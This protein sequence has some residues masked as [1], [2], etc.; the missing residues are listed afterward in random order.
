[1]Q[2]VFEIVGDPH[3]GRRSGEPV[4]RHSRPAGRCEGVFWR[5]FDRK[6][7]S[8]VLQ[9]AER[10]DALTRRNRK[11]GGRNG[12]LGHIGRDVLRELLRLI[13]YRTGRLDPAIGTLAERLGYSVPAV[14][15]ALKRLRAA[16][17]VDWL[18][19]Y[20]PTGETGRGP[21]VQQTSNAYRVSLP[22]QAARL[23]PAPAPLP[24]DF[25][26]DREERARRT[27]EAV[28]EDS[29]LGRSFARLGA[30]LSSRERGLTTAQESPSR[31]I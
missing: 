3:K 20:V 16:G 22:P 15:A 17:F 30:V 23:I 18:R 27:A 31:K 25:A 8:R 24:D 6:A 11:K 26:H 9:A 21:R 7:V 4:R 14:V 5:P 2:T 28:F 1:M 19:R 10:F 29:P 12:A 13:D